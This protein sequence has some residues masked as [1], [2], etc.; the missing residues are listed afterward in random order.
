MSIRIKIIYHILRYDKQK[1]EKLKQGVFTMTKKPDKILHILRQ[2]G[3][4]AYYVG[5]CVRDLL[6]GREVHDWDITTS[7]LPE[8]TMA[9]FE[10]CVP[11]G[12]KHGTVTVLQDDTSAEVTTYRTD[13]SYLDG[14][15]PEQVTF[16]RTLAEDLARRDFTVNAMA[17]DESGNITDLYGGREDLRSRIIRCVGD[18]DRRFGEDA[19]RMLRA[20]RFSA[21]LGFEIE[22]NTRSAIR[23][24]AHL[25]QNLSAERVR[26]EVE[27]TLCSA[28]VNKLADMA[29]YGLLARF[30][31]EADA[32]LGWICGLPDEPSVRWAALCRAWPKLE[33]SAMRLSKKI[34]LD[35]QTAGRLPVPSDE[36]GWKTVLVEHGA[37]KGRLLAAL[38]GQSET[39]DTILSSG[40]CLSLRDLAVSGADFPQLHGPELGM[41]L[42]KL[43][44]HVLEHPQDNRKEILLQIP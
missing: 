11:T 16:V 7:A 21:Q 37:E 9:C 13:G 43:L 42:K 39:V 22:E 18:A 41:H 3:Y 4:E 1:M 31:P 38:A 33:L 44:Q 14:R 17:M 24:N 23:R 30:S 34:I 15:H 29:Q 20:L 32:D 36:I 6:L 12:I 10:R 5:G 25:A 19:L 8:Q 40:Q 26:D 2:N 28:C 35:S 27:K